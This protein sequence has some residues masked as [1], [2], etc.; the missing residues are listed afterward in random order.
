[1]NSQMGLGRRDLNGNKHWESNIPKDCFLQGKNILILPGD[2]TNDEYDANAVCKIVECFLNNN[3]IS[4]FEGRIYST[5]YPDNDNC[6]TH[7]L[8]QNDTLNQLD[9]RLYPIIKKHYNYYEQFFNTWL[10]PLISK[11]NG[12]ARLDA[13]TAAKNMRNLSIISHCHGGVVLLDLE[14][15]FQQNMQRLGYTEAEQIQLQKQ[16]FVLDVAS[17]MPLGRTKSTVLHITSQQDKSA[18]KNWRLGNLNRF[19]QEVMLENSPG[20]LME[21]SSNENLLLLNRIYD[22]IKCMEQNIFTPNEHAA[23]TYLD[24]STYNDIRDCVSDAIL[25]E[26]LQTAANTISNTS[27]IPNIAEL[28]PITSQIEQMRNDG[29]IYLSRFQQYRAKLFDEELKMFDGILRHDSKTFKKLPCIE[30]LFRRDVYNKSA[31]EYI[32][33]SE[34]VGLVKKMMDY[35]NA[36]SKNNPFRTVPYRYLEKAREY[37]FNQ[38]LFNIYNKLIENGH[39]GIPT[40][41]CAENMQSEDIPS[42]IPS[43]KKC[44]LNTQSLFTLL[45]LYMKSAEIA[46]EN[47]R[48]ETR[49]ILFTMLTPQNLSI[50]NAFLLY[51]KAGEFSAAK[52]QKLQKAYQ[53]HISAS[54]IKCKNFSELYEAEKTQQ[55][56]KLL[57][58]LLSE[59]AKEHLEEVCHNEKI[60]IFD[61]YVASVLRLGNLSEYKKYNVLYT[62]ELDQQGQADF[63]KKLND[64]HLKNHLKTEPTAI[65]SAKF[66]KYIRECNPDMKPTQESTV[67]KQFEG[68]DD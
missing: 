40:Q 34:D 59:R 39:D 42:V 49:S 58:T 6:A 18:V 29:H 38:K 61:R 53:Q 47:I 67:I 45:P 7:R 68:R 27:S 9:D 63:L 20:A 19:T 10:L 14:N 5:Y 13:E 56:D 37:N 46:D 57:Y 41:I 21:L 51:K 2:G 62:R 24:I 60:N 1:M 3:N 4:G 22:D 16:L 50:R 64:F 66:K 26:I 30:L 52:P 31:F 12:K 8:N 55:S 11:N 17:A 43:L 15:L 54:I 44:R 23:N 25:M 32:V 35:F 65:L 28:F 48:N 36:Q 33:E